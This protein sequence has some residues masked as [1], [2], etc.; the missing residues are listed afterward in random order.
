MS[1]E[2]L[3]P[4]NRAANGTILLHLQPA[5]YSFID[6]LPLFS[7]LGPD[8]GMAEPFSGGNCLRESSDPDQMA[9]SVR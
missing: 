9:N 2:K 8:L 1:I 5:R 3:F 6:K 7:V 4:E